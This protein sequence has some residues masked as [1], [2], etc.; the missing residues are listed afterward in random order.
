MRINRTHR[1]FLLSFLLIFAL[2]MSAFAA[3]SIT[4]QMA[5]NSAAWHEAK[6]NGDTDA[7]KALEQA[8]KDLANEL[9]GSGGSAERDENG[10][11]TIETEDGDKITSSSSSSGKT[12]DV[13]YETEDDDGNKSSTT[14]SS[15]SE[16]ANDAYKD[17]GGTNEDI[18]NA[19][20]NAGKDV[21]NSGD[22]SDEHTSKDAETEA[23]LAQYLLG[24]TDAQRDALEDALKES[25]EAFKDARAEYDDAKAALEEALAN[26]DSAAAAEAQ[27]RIDASLEAQNEAHAAAEAARNSYGYTSEKSN[28][29]D[30]GG[31]Y[32]DLGGSGSSS[33][34]GSG[35]ANSGDGDDDDFIITDI[36]NIKKSYN[37]TASAGTGGTISPNGTVAVAEGSDKTF[38]ITPNEGYVIDKVL[39]DGVN[40]GAVS[41]YKFEDIKAAHTI[42]ASFKVKTY[43]ITSSA[44]TGGKISP[45][46]TTSINHGSD[47]TYTI[48]PNAGYK[49]E[50]VVVDGVNK[51]AVSSYKFSNVTVAHIITASFI[52]DAESDITNAMFKDSTGANLNGRT[53]KSGYGFYADVTAS[54][55]NVTDVRMTLKYN[56]GQGNKTVQ[57][58]E[59]SEGKFV[60]PKNSASPD[61]LRCVYIPVETRDATYT[62]TLT[63][64]AKDVEGNTLTDTATATIVV[65][66]SMYE[67]DFTGDS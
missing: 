53:I 9:A 56:F 27:A 15:F 55:E 18:E 23:N 36:E 6:A 49:I 67:D 38:T 10:R 39:V 58:V 63:M 32:G 40:K 13:T 19:Y 51:G 1:T 30:D 29:D 12:T 22:Y 26:G 31:F 7:M 14:S 34:S 33:T 62:L 17:V 64:T 45:N 54:Y 28:T 21:Q 35:P 20:N 60:F 41:S 8:N 24:L 16:E 25:K 42:T 37:I 59:T 43:T 48:T 5:A 50:K 2:F 47:K 52:P 4:D 11:W 3:K 46:G 44:G 65:K 66:G 57:L 61:R